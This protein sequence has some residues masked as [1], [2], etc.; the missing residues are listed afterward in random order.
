M[1]VLVLGLYAEGSTD[2]RFLSPVIRRTTEE[3]LANYD[4]GNMWDEAII[5]RIRLNTGQYVNRAQSILAAAAEAQGCHIL[6]VHADADGPTPDRALAERFQPGLVLVK[7]AGKKVCQDLLP[8]IPIQ[9]I[10][11]WLLV[12]RETLLKE[13]KV[14]QNTRIS[15]IPPVQRI[16]STA[17]PKEELDR[18]I[19]AI[20]NAQG[21]AIGR[22]ELYEP[23]GETVRLERL[24][25]LSAYN[26]FITDLTEALTNLG[27][28][29]RVSL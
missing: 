17:R 25:A 12:D 3:I 8:V 16:E 24:A 2:E 29:S 22:K 11:A 7:Q 21:R 28:I 4:G 5:M 14:N 1:R 18:I 23:L 20:N 15:G 27:I 9:E 26:R 6:I 10:E 19:R 13:L